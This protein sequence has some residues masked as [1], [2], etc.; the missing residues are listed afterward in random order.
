MDVI[1]VQNHLSNRKV[2]RIVLVSAS[3]SENSATDKLGERIVQS[4]QSELEKL[5]QDVTIYRVSLRLRAH[6]V[7]NA[8]L[9]GFAS[10]ELEAD[11]EAVSAAD[12]VIAVSPTYNASCSG[13]FKSFFDVLPEDSLCNKPMIIGATGGTPRHSL[14]VEHALRPLFTYLHAHIASTAVFAATEDWGAHAQD[15]NGAGG[16]ALHSRTRRAA[17]ELVSIMKVEKCLGTGSWELGDSNIVSDSNYDGEPNVALDTP[18][19]D[20]YPE[21][22]SFDQLSHNIL[23]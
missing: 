8:M 17:Q 10:P 4:V 11:F 3:L 23:K 14:I 9:A 13:L 22:K 5:H 6:D 15:S 16:I 2:L 7:V 21:F 12:A 1:D 19:E 18:P 20:L